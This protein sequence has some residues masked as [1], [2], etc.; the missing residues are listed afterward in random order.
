MAKILMVVLSTRIE[1]SDKCY[2]YGDNIKMI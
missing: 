2:Y 1:D